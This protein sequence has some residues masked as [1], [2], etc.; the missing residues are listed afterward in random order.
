MST[1]FVTPALRTIVGTFGALLLATVCIGAAAGPA[2][3][4][5][6]SPA[7]LSTRVA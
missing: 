6:A 5:S 2:Q 4:G 1:T 3:A 7:F